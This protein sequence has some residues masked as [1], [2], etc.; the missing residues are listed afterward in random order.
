MKTKSHQL[1]RVTLESERLMR[2]IRAHTYSRVE[3]PSLSF[4]EWV[5]RACDER[6]NVDL[7]GSP[8]KSAGK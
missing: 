5:R 6:S 4:A 8:K 2:Y 7:G 3:E 1:P